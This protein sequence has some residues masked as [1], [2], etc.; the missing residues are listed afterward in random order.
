MDDVLTEHPPAA[1][2][3][4]WEGYHKAVDKIRRA[5]PA[6]CG[7]GLGLYLSRFLAE[8]IPAARPLVQL[9]PLVIICG[10]LGVALVVWGRRYIPHYAPLA[11]LYLYI[12]YPF[13][14]FHLAARLAFL[15]LC[16]LLILNTQGKR[17]LPSWALDLG[18]FGGALALYWRTLAPTVLPADSG[19]FQFVSYVLGIA[20]PPGYPLYTLL[21]KLFTLIPLGDVA[22]RV[23]LLSAVIAALTLAG[24]YRLA[25]QMTGSTWLGLVPALALGASPTFWA[26]GTTANIRSL[27]ALFTSWQLCF[28][29][30]YSQRRDRDSLLGFALSFG[31]G[32]AHHG[33]LGLLA[34]PYL[35]YLW[36]VDPS[37]LRRWRDWLGPL[38][39]FLASFLV[40]LYLPLRS[41]MGAPFDPVP[42]RSLDTFLDHVLARGFR[43]DMFAF[44]RPDLLL[45]R[46]PVL[47]NILVFQFGYPLLA[48]A[49]LGVLGSL[50]WERRLF[51]LFA[52]AFGVNAFV[53]ITYRAPQTVEYLLPAYVALAALIGYGAGVLRR[54]RGKVVK[55]ILAAALLWLGGENLSRHYPSYLALSRDT[56]TREYAEALLREAPPQAVILA[57]WHY[58]T[59]LWY[60]QYA[61][62]LRPDVGVEY[63][64]PE[65]AT[66]MSEIWQERI[67]RRLRVR[68]VIV[69]NHYAEFDRLPYRFLPFHRAERV[70]ADRLFEMPA[71]MTPL[72]I[73]FEG[74]IRFAGYQLPSA[75]VTSGD[76]LILRLC[77]QPMQPLDRDYSFFV[78]LVAPAGGPPLGQGDKTHPAARYQVGEVLVDEYRIPLLPTTAAGRYALMAGVYI[79]LPQGGWQRLRTSEGQDAL[80]LAEVT[81]RPLAQ[82]P[83]TTHP[84]QMPFANGLQCVGVDYDTSL[85]GVLR[86][87][88]HWHRPRGVNGLC[89]AL[90]YRGTQL[91]ARGSMP[92]AQEYTTIAL[93]VPLAGGDL[94]LEV[95]S[96][97]EDARIA[98]LGLWHRVTGQKV[99]LPAPCQGERHIVL[100]GE[101]SLE[102][103][104]WNQEWTPGGEGRISLRF[105]GRRPITQDYSVSVSLVGADGCLIGQHDTTPAMGA[106]P[107]FKWIGGSLVDDL[108]LI[109][110]PAQMGNGEARLR[111]TVYDAFTL[112]PLAI[113]DERLSRL[114]QGTQIELGRVVIRP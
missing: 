44:A 39:I 8:S 101:M 21:G 73:T 5:G 10:I 83:V 48:V 42:I 63:L 107:T 52:G 2:R 104:T 41:L 93:D 38:A 74:K 70:I 59:P 4:L 51:L 105:Q 77:W 31:L 3:K 66:P 15:V 7:L 17:G 85:P 65:G 58:A 9:L 30:R 12:V 36:V 112:R 99:R 32:M 11:L 43:G 111:L 67:T 113:G 16:A 40:F 87:Y 27:T 106:I 75:S 91:I 19:E 96:A 114:G 110:L 72:D 25:R 95:R 97:A 23:N 81:V 56:S 37:L 109:P 29:F 49:C 1:F 46:L 22:Y 82:P 57:N 13:V 100:G 45:N 33:S 94:R 62:G 60:L 20:H 34:I 76:D 89:D 6:I 55:A 47:I 28:L 53:A 88:L 24:L 26:Q 35:L 71:E 80:P 50:I 90:L 78:H 102:R 64:N 86:V 79:T 14:S 108:H 68:P 103:A 69:T 61:E 92:L 54:W 18:V 84:L 98:P